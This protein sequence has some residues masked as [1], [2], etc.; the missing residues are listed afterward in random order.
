MTDKKFEKTMNMIRKIHDDVKEQ[1]K[2]LI[3]DGTLTTEMMTF[4]YGGDNDE[5]EVMHIITHPDGTTSEVTKIYY[6]D[7]S[8]RVSEYD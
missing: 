6:L 8:L 3:R 5:L 4:E 1:V 7:F 2:I